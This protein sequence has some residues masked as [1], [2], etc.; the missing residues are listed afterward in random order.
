VNGKVV[1]EHVGSGPLAELSAELD[2]NQR[3]LRRLE[4]AEARIDQDAF[5]F[6]VADVFAVDEVLGNLFAILAGRC[7]AYR[8][9]RQ[10]R[11]KRRADVMGVLKKIAR[12][13][14][15]VKAELDSDDRKRPLMA[16]DFS[17]VPDEDREVLVAAA[18]GDEAALEK[19]Q[20]YLKDGRYI[21]RWG[22]PMYAAKCWLV[23]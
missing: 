17:G 2:T 1:T 8:H 14:E 19:A 7:G 5:L 16:P 12:D 15:R 21:A 3:M 4:R 6:G 18:K 13:I 9:R 22:S 11:R 10:W 23:G 20:P